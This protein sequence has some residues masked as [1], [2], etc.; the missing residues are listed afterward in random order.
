MT[1]VAMPDTKRH[2][3]ENAQSKGRRYLIEGR[4]LI[5][6]VQ[7]GHVNAVVRGTERFHEVQLRDG[8]WN[9]SCFAKTTCSHLVAVQ[10]VTM[11]TEIV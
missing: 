3:R 4:V 10:L 9:C 8:S 7:P 11:R 1:T 5:R 6:I 2:G